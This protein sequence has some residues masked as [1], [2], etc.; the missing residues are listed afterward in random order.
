MSDL[1]AALQTKLEGLKSKNQDFADR[2][3]TAALL[4]DGEQTSRAQLAK[5]REL[6]KGYEAILLALSKAD[7]GA[8]T[9]AGQS[10]REPQEAEAVLVEM[11]RAEKHHRQLQSMAEETS[12]NPA[13]KVGSLEA[14]RAAVEA[15]RGLAEAIEARIQKLAA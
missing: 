1:Q 6:R 5:L 10:S 14:I 9:R 11:G 8:M 3:A 13:R 4:A 12:R 15:G 2:E 7:V